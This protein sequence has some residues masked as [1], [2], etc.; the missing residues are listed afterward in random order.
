MTADVAETRGA[1][2]GT[3]DR[4]VE[5]LRNGIL[6]G[7]YV[8]GQRLVEAD[9]THD[10]GVSRG[11][12]REAFGRLSAE[13]LLQIVPHRGAL[14]RKL[15]YEET[16]EIFQIRSGLEPLAARLAAAAIDRADNRQRFE[17]GIRQIWDEAPRMDSGYHRE[18]RQFHLS[19]FEVCGNAQLVGLSR[20][21][22]LPLILMQ[23][24]NTKT[25]EMYRN[26]VEE[27]RAVATAIL[28]G[29]GDAAE[30]AMRR[31]LERAN[32]DLATMPQSIF[33]ETF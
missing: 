15:C 29:D 8:P 13:G 26:S 3:V 32:Y 9:L 4:L 21:L 25:P 10:F 2:G 24:S 27:H 31:H 17:A 22:Q 1:R 11:P 18:N 30:A 5:W 23:L 7:R 19:I 33:D 20:Q 28:R 12:L 16:V 14:V 6:N